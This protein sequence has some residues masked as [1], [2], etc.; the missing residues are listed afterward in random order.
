[1]RSILFT[2]L[3]VLVIASLSFFGPLA[4]GQDKPGSPEVE[5]K[6][7][8][9][10]ADEK[11]ATKKLNELAKD[12]WE[13]VGP[14]GSGLVAFKRRTRSASEIE[15]EKFQGTWIL[16]SK[17]EGGQVNRTQDDTTTITFAGTKRLSGKISREF[18]GCQHCV[19]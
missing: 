5:Y 13:Y 9:F 4:A 19:R 7:V 2:L 18:C 11:E 6:A 3:G 8:L 17:E 1:M 14:L 16:V 10:G 15:L 12:G